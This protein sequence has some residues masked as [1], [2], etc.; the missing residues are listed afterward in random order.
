MTNV[1]RDN[2]CCTYDIT[3]PENRTTMGDLRT[4]F[5]THCK[6]YSFQLEKGEST[7]YLHFQCRISLKVKQRITA[8]IK[9]PLN[10]PGCNI[11]VTSTANAGND[12]YTTKQD[13]RVDGPWTDQ[14]KPV[15]KTV[16][17]MTTLYPWQESLIHHVTIPNDREVHVIIDVS[18]NNGKSS[19]AKYMWT[20]YDAQPIPPLNQAKDL[21]QFTMG[22]SKKPIYIIDMP[23]A[24]KKKDLFELYSGIEQLKNGMV[25]DTR[26]HARFEYFDE[27]QVIVFTNTMPKMRY[28]SRDRWKLWSIID[29][30]LVE[31]SE[32]TYKKQM[33][34]NKQV[35]DI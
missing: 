29:K 10:I 2:P 8:V 3:Y 17:K 18:G 33:T 35:S 20:H 5:S 11:T 9:G 27:P 19:F 30:K 1:Q 7:G 22:F 16:A 23:R 4:M 26:Y 6:K 34:Y 15:L 28:L 32:E 24:M 21:A 31:F 12:F 14:D 25:Y 13:T